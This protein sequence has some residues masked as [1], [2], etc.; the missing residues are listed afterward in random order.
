MKTAKFIL[1]LV[2]LLFTTNHLFAQLYTVIERNPDKSEKERKIRIKNNISESFEFIH[3]NKKDSILRS[4][5]T[6]N[7]N[8][9]LITDAIFSLKKQDTINYTINEYLNDKLVKSSLYFKNPKNPVFNHVFNRISNYSYDKNGNNNEVQTINEEGKIVYQK[10]D[11]DSD[12]LKKSLNVKWWDKTDFSISTEYF[13]SKNHNLIKEKIYSSNGHPTRE[14][15]HEYDDLGRLITNHIMTQ[16]GNK[17]SYF[18]SYD[19]KNNLTESNL[20]FLANSRPPYE[21]KIRYEY[22]TYNN[23]VKEYHIEDNT[24]KSIRT[25]CYKKFK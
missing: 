22:D 6:Y 14:I 5:K 23:V 13:Y 4:H 15:E 3:K 16:S 12:N 7:K 18:Y 17:S 1:F 20:K 24:V 10:M 11:Y 8:G 25:F 2:I 21:N 19:E 9:D